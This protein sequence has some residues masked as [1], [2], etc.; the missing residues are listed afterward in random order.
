[1]TDV[2]F[3]GLGDMG[4]PMAG[5]LA[6]AGHDV[7]AYD[8][9]TDALERAVEAGATA[10]AD[11]SDAVSGAEVVFFS[12]P[13]PGAVEQVVEETES[14]FSDGMV[15]A[16]LTTSTPDTTTAVHERLAESGVTVLGAPV[17]GGKA[18][19]KAGTLS[20]MAGGDRATFEACEPLFE[21]FAAN[22]FHVGAN[23]GAGHAV[24]LLNNYLSFTALLA[25][26]EAVVLGKEAGLDPETLID[27][28]NV[29]SGRNS[30]TED[31][32]PEQVLTGEFDAGF[33]LPLMEKDARLF[34][35]FAADHGMPL[36]L[37]DTVRNL[38]GYARAVEG[39]DGD[40]T[41]VYPFMERVMS[42]D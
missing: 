32:F 6:E 35:E 26:S 36:L 1:M 37:G 3:I 14:G 4:G 21:T 27:V 8:L 42:R 13:T 11:S 31:K 18:G 20:V 24:K 5:H 22:V 16:D 41:D 7:Q 15:L 19:A 9:D 23:P 38:V 40:M 30:A 29:S 28:F 10:A 34:A 17:S 12:L 2:G 33:K 39:E 25:T